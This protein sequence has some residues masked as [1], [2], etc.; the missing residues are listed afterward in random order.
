LLANDLRARG[1]TVVLTRSN[2]SSL[3]PC[4]NVRGESGQLAHAD[5]S[6]SIHADGGPALGHGFAVLVPAGVGPSAAMASRAMNLAR[7]I[8]PE[9]VQTGM[10]TSTY[11]GQDGLARRSDLAGLN[12]ST[13]PKVLIECGN[14]RNASDAALQSN[15][16][17]QVRAAS[18]LA[19][20]IAAFL[21]RS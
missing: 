6:I 4:V 16:A 10:T 2:D 8:I 11:D 18:A 12:L 3:G 5:V 1:A 9:F 15:P 14:M 19:A 21:T 17:W 13:V 20:G 7:D